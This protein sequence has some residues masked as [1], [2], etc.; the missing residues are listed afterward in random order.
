MNKRVVVFFSIILVGS[1]IFSSVGSSIFSSVINSTWINESLSDSSGTLNP[2]NLSYRADGSPV[3]DSFILV[4][5]KY[6]SG[7]ISSILQNPESKLGATFYGIN[8]ALSLGIY[9]YLTQG[10]EKSDRFI[11][12]GHTI[13][14]IGLD[15]GWA[16]G[17]VSFGLS[18]SGGS[19]LIKNNFYLRNNAFT[20]PDYFVNT[21]FSRYEVV[22]SSQF[23]KLGFGFRYEIFDNFSI[24]IVSTSDLSVYST[25]KSNLD[26]ADYLKNACIGFSKIT[27]KYAEN[28]ELN[29]LRFK[30]FTDLLYVGNNDNR[31]KRISAEFRLQLSRD[32]YSSIYFGLQEKDDSILKLFLVDV[33]KASSHFGLTFSWNTYDL[34]LNTEV[35]LVYYSGS[36]TITD[37]VVATVKFSYQI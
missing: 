22:S 17:P 34:I 35:P 31:E 32:F 12:I 25:S 3:F 24:G 16:T 2:A 6:H 1:S 37:Y 20:I 4:D 9:N 23:F 14:S 29:L 5:D 30:Y 28:G 21:F 27:P 8:L 15:W 26:F 18:M 19:E 13:Y 33:D 11:Y 36:N 7:N 10:E